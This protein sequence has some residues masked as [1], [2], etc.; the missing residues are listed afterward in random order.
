MDLLRELGLER[1]TIVFFSSDNGPTYDRLGGS[2]SEFFHSAGLFRGLKGSLYEGG[3][4]VPLIVRWPQHIQADTV[5]SHVSAFWDI[6]PTICDLTQINPPAQ[7][8]GMSMAPAL[9]GQ[10][11]KQHE[12]LYWEFQD[13]GGQQ[14]VRLEDWKAIRTG[15]KEKG[16]GTRIQVYN[17]GTDAG[18][19]NNVAD[20]HPEIVSRCRNIMK[21]ARVESQLFPF[22]EILLREM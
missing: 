21:S 9:L 14:A 15:L 1:N 3:I 6:L 20:H 5:N 11:Q 22:P 19:T 4:R 18:E 12:F 10:P 2:D 16:T 13:Y 7:I 17:L 8:D